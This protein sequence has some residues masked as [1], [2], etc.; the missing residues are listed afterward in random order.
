MAEKRASFLVKSLKGRSLPA[1]KKKR[2]KE[3][4]LKGEKREEE[5][6]RSKGKRKW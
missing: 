3:K 5:F 1:K 6:A 4:E 2:K